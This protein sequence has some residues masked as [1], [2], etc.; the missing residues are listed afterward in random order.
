MKITSILIFILLLLSVS[1]AHAANCRV[2]KSADT[3]DGA[4][5]AGDCS[6]RE[7]VAE[8]SCTFI[9]FSLDLVGAPVSLTMGELVLSRSMSVSGWGSDAVTITA[10]DL[11]R[12]FYVSEGVTVN[13][14]GV[15]LTGG[16]GTGT[17]PNNGGAVR[18][19]GITNF[20]GVCL[21]GN[22]AP[23]VGG[24]VSFEGPA[25][26]K[27]MRNTS[28]VFNT[29]PNTPASKA[30]IVTFANS[31]L[32]KIRNSTIAGNSGPGIFVSASQVSLLN[33]T[34]AFN[35]QWGVFVGLNGFLGMTNSVV[36]NIFRGSTLALV[37]STGDNIVSTASGSQ[38]IGYPSTDMVGADPMLAGPQYNAAH[39]LTMAPMPGSPMIDR[40][41]NTPVTNDPLA[42]DQRGYVRIVDGDG[43][44]TATVDI[45]AFEFNSVAAAAPVSVSGRVLTAS[46]IPLRSINVSI[47][48]LNGGNVQQA[49]TS[50]LGWFTFSQV[51]GNGVYRI[52]ISSKRYN[53]PERTIFTDHGITD[54]DII[55]TQYGK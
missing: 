22:H 33:T 48:D 21:T 50:S 23:E 2:T 54:A 51:P 52:S 40:G 14:S 12:I 25:A 31:G 17:T 8:P 28:V 42:T 20:D 47:S 7:A 5:T 27:T 9:D 44:S 26:D 6:L 1:I 46:G 43:D 53:A 36:L 34:L 3:N 13:I 4:C 16:N 38:P 32:L 29:G 10:N 18:S 39:V 55:A 30:A 41:S 49:F 24:A 37:N 11:S 19:L 45:G 15:T 35:G